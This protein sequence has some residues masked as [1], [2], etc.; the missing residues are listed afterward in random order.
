ML[1]A[2]LVLAQSAFADPVTL[3]TRNGEVQV[4]GDVLSF[5]GAYIRIETEHGPVTLEVGGMTCVGADCPAAADLVAVARFVGSDTLIHT[6]VPNL[7]QGFAA[8]HGLEPRRVFA[9]D[10]DETWH[11]IDN[12]KKL[13]EFRL[14]PASP[15]GAVDALRDR[16][17]DI[18]FTTVE[19]T[20]EMRRDV[21]ALDATVPIVAP[22]NPRA[23]LTIDEMRDI[24]SGNNLWPDTR[25]PLT[26]HLL[27]TPSTGGLWAV[28][29]TVTAMR[30]VSPEELSD[31]VSRDPEAIG[32]V[33]LSNIGNAVPLVIGGAC[34]LVAVATPA[35]VKS[36]DYP[37][38][39][40]QFL[41]RI[42][43]QQHRLVR[44]FVAYARSPEAQ[45]LIRS[46]GYVD[47]AI[48]RVSFD[49]QGNRL[50]E[51]VLA[52]R[53]DPNGMAEVQRLVSALMTG[54]RLTLTFRFRDGESTLD[55]QS[56]SNIRRLADALRR[57][58]F[59]GQRIVFVGFSDGI[60]DA[61]A[62]QRL[63]MR[64]AR[65]VQTAVAAQAG[66][67]A[68]DLSVEG[69]GELMPMAC[70]DVPWGRR[71]NRRVEVWA[72]PHQR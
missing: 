36:E 26:L 11:L 50:A 64:R 21:V 27:D 12:G 25:R 18:A 24:L 55:A 1:S 52:S 33:Q 69:F 10:D 58:A 45:P 70:D 71:V 53:Q 60:G 31:A 28:R 34:G 38:V 6:L 48:G 51:A 66:E 17:A 67:A 43:A 35:T 15:T 5:D 41:L 4:T 20:S 40:P 47:Q 39:Q 44:D 72:L 8:A 59:D 7:I 9:G 61:E 16:Q 22:D 19:G 46:S 57:G 63:S 42:G 54:D 29:S 62:N 68:K 2:I 65:A 3:T 56:E 49:R 23:T 32:L 14:T 30:H 37:F 13:A